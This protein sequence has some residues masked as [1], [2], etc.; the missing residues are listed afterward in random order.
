MSG[1]EEYLRNRAA[2]LEPSGTRLLCHPDEVT[3]REAQD[4]RLLHQF[5]LHLV[6]ETHERDPFVPGVVLEMH[7][8]CVAGI[9]PSG[10]RFREMGETVDV[11]GAGFTP[12]P[13]YRIETEIRDLLARVRKV[14][15]S[16]AR[17]RWRVNYAAL[18]L[19]RFLRIH[20]FLDGNGRVGRAFHQIMLY[21]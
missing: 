2:W 10:G 5:V 7:R 11:P 1:A 20:P 12:I 13:V 3:E 4:L 17:F 19:H 18:A 14:V 16:P 6:Q 8:I 15:D 9:Y 21:K